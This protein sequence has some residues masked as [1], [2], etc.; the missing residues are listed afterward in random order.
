MIKTIIVADE[1]PNVRRQIKERLETEGFQIIEA[2]DGDMALDYALEFNPCLILAEA[3]MPVMD[4]W[5][6][7]ANKRNYTELNGIPIILIGEFREAADRVKAIDLEADDYITK[8]LQMDD[9]VAR[10]YLTLKK[11]KERKLSSTQRLTEVRLE[12]ELDLMPL[13][14]LV[15]HFHNAKKSGILSIYPKKKQEDNRFLFP[16]AKIYFQSGNLIHAKLEKLKGPK[17][18]MRV[19]SWN[20][21]SFHFEEKMP[22]CNQTIYGNIMSLLMESMR[23]RDELEV[24]K[25]DLPP[26]D[27]MLYINFSKEFFKWGLVHA[28]PNHIKILTLLNRYHTIQNMMNSTDMEDLTL[29]R[30]ASFLWQKGFISI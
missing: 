30:E 18:L 16:E 14:D 21:G 7:C 28:H 10:V 5:S 1:D 4:G 9:V 25:Q 13:T 19:L 22:T 23:L 29:A 17:A 12:G 26:L 11:S 2:E 3:D 20:N 27:S 8:P 24:L 15:Q 6:L